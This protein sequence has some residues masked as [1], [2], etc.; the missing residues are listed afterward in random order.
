MIELLARSIYLPKIPDANQEPC[1][2]QTQGVKQQ[3]HRYVSLFL[4]L[5]LET[6]HGKLGTIFI[7]LYTRGVGLIGC[8]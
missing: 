7:D 4:R 1:Q 5:N 2:N 8:Q 6:D 3:D